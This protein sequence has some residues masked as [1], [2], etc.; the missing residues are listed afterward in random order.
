MSTLNEE[1]EKMVMAL[2]K[3]GSIMKE[4]WTNEEKEK[5]KVISDCQKYAQKLHNRVNKD[6]FP[7]A[8]DSDYE[9]YHMT[10]A[11]VGELGE[12]SDALKKAIVYRKELDNKNVLE[13]CGDICFFTQGIVS[14]FNK[15][16]IRY[17]SLN[18]FINNV[19]V[20]VNS[21]FRTIGISVE[22]A[23]RQNMDKLGE[24]YKKFQYSDEQ[25][26]KRSDKNFVTLEFNLTDNEKLIVDF[27][28]DIPKVCESGKDEPISL[29]TTITDSVF[30]QE[31][32]IQMCKSKIEK[33]G[34]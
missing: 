10:Y 14:I 2:M 27:Y 16:S 32:L 19:M 26:Q 33:E 17:L 24:R 5:L 30:D 3:K 13:E 31:L 12:L 21:L 18:I 15:N 20:S 23:K 1:Y 4:E 25:A 8:V 9:L 7:M 11:L 29:Y 6:Y 34:K 22:D 28:P